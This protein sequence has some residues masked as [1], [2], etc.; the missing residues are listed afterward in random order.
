MCCGS[1]PSTVLWLPQPYGTSKY[2]HNFMTGRQMYVNYL[3]NIWSESWLHVMLKLFLPFFH[4]YCCV[5]SILV[6]GPYWKSWI[7]T[8]NTSY[9][10][11]LSWSYY[12]RLWGHHQKVSKYYWHKNLTISSNHVPNYVFFIHNLTFEGSSCGFIM[13]ESLLILNAT[14]LEQLLWFH[15]VLNSKILFNPSFQTKLSGKEIRGFF[16]LPWSSSQW[17]FEASHICKAAYSGY[18]KRSWRAKGQEIRQWD[19]FEVE[20]FF[21]T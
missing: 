7:H 19:I 13:W 11:I 10:D 14:Y 16:I 2:A 8:T 18:F 21:T 3:Q 15:T 12:G 1:R 17:D 6:N 20:S 4:K 5:S 9:E